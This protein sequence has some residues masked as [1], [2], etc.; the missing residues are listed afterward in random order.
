MKKWAG[1]NSIFC[2]ST[3]FRIS[4]AC[5]IMKNSFKTWRTTSDVL[6][7]KVNTE[8]SEGILITNIN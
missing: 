3:S 1:F 7:D 2:N 6:N 8:T 4:P 5:K